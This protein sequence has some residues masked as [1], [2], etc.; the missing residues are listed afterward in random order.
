[1]SEVS[2]AFRFSARSAKSGMMLRSV[3]LVAVSACLLVAACAEPPKPDA[4]HAAQP[5]RDDSALVVLEPPTATSEQAEEVDRQPAAQAGSKPDAGGRDER[6]AERFARKRPLAVQR[7]SAS[8]YSDAFAGRRTAS[9]AVYEP[10]G[11]TAAHRSLPFGSVLR[12]T[13]SDGARTV[14]VRVT[15]RGPYGPKGRILDLSR[16]AAEELGMLRAGVVKIKLEVVEYGQPR[17][18]RRRRR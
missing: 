12:V 2:S 5:A 18:P 8:Y 6:L 17:K 4:R 3:C 7:G 11:M 14:Y 15:D 13:R 10:G 1:M 9:G 16:A